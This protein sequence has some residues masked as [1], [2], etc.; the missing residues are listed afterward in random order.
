V[1]FVGSELG[2][3]CRADWRHMGSVLVCVEP[4]TVYKMAATATHQPVICAPVRPIHWQQFCVDARRCP[5]VVNIA[6]M[7]GSMNRCMCLP[8]AL[9]WVL[10]VAECWRSGSVLGCRLCGVPILAAAGLTHQHASPG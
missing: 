3:V 6:R 8:P 7:F 5:Q 9:R 10:A 4:A 1:W 2:G